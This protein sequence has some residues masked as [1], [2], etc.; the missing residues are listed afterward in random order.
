[1]EHW[2]SRAIHHGSTTS[3][4]SSSTQSGGS[5]AA[6]RLADVLAQT[7]V[8]KPGTT[9]LSSPSSLSSSSSSSSSFSAPFSYSAPPLLLLFSSSSSFSS[10][11]SSSSSSSFY[12]LRLNTTLTIAVVSVCF[13]SSSVSSVSVSLEQV[14]QSEP[15]AVS[16]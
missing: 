16:C 4:S 5:G 15:L 14:C 12:N 11:F 7:H 13:L 3:S 1:M 10:F 9:P 2:I 8:G 6:S